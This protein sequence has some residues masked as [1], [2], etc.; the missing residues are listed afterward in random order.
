MGE[1]EGIQNILET[2]EGKKKYFYWGLTV[3]LVLCATISFY[4]CIFHFERVITILKSFLDTIMPILDGFILAYLL[5]P[6]LNYIEKKFFG[7]KEYSR[8]SIK[9]IRMF[10]VLITV[11]LFALFLYEFFALI[12]PEIRISIV[13]IADQSETYIANLEGMLNKIGEKYPELG[14][15]VENFLNDYSGK[16][17]SYINDTIL[18]KMNDFIVVLTN[19]LFSAIKAVWYFILGLIISIYLL[20]NKELYL[21]QVKKLIYA[22]LKRNTANVLIHNLRFTHKTFIGFIGGKIIDS[23][24]IGFLCFI[25]TTIIGTPYPILISVIIGVTNVI[26]FFGPYLGAIPSAL[27]VLMVDPMQCL[28]FIIMIFLLQQF[29]GNF[30]GPKILGNST[31]LSG[32]WVIFSITLFGGLLGIP[33]MIIGVPLFAVIYA[34][35]KS[36]VQTRLTEKQLL[37]STDKYIYTDYIDD[38]NKYIKIPKEE[39]SGI[40]EHKKNKK[41]ENKNQ[42]NDSSQSKES[43][44]VANKTSADTAENTNKTK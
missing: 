42:I 19:G 35:T 31:G 4:F 21:G 8:E 40:V 39:I 18:P 33:G 38:D 27:L 41:A 10:T 5:A 15:Y 12:I 43:N 32:F 20:Y 3:F 30:L 25:L 26:P 34:G 6:I 16:I 22:V 7:K 44:S 29:D 28:Y 13:S 2:N 11:V 37:L 24:I 9:K 1:N 17:D 14:V 36:F 23:I